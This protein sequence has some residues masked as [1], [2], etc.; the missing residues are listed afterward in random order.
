MAVQGEGR[1]GT[2]ELDGYG[3]VTLAGVNPTAQRL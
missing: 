3:S 1:C 2:A